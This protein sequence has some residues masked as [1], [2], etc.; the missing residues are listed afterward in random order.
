MRSLASRVRHAAVLACLPLV[1]T[2]ACND[3]T[4]PDTADISGTYTLQSIAGVT[5]PYSFQPDATTTITLTSDVL[6]VN[7]DG[8]WTETETVQQ[9]ANGQTT[10][11]TTSDGGTWTRSGTTVNF[12]SQIDGSLVYVGTYGDNTLTL[13]AGDGLAQVFRR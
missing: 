8:T 2:L 4:N 7:R 3:S 1:V 6:T 12:A 5:L 13:D 9:V 10:T 11:N